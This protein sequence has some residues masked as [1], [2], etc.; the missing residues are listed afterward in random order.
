MAKDSL[1]TVCLREV[2]PLHRLF[3]SCGWGRLVSIARL[4]FLHQFLDYW[5]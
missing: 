4:L 3:Y 2:E 1:L 5:G